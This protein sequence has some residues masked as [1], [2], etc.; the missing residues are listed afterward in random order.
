MLAICELCEC[1]DDHEVL[2]SRKENGETWAHLR[3]AQCGGEWEEFV[4]EE[5]N[6]ELDDDGG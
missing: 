2:A 6:A 4:G 1:E 5:G 3:C